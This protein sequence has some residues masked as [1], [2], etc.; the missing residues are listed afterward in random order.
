MASISNIARRSICVAA[1]RTPRASMVPRLNCIR[2]TAVAF[3][4]NAVSQVE[5]VEGML[6]NL[7]W[8]DLKDNAHEL[9]ELMNEMK[10]NRAVRKP[11]A[12][13]EAKVAQ[14]MKEIQKMFAD[15]EGCRDEVGRRVTGLKRMMKGQLYA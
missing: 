7:R 3:S 9:R 12:E 8:A 13:L 2:P 6:K 10:T 1:T 5:A 15:P 14:E 11:G 4:T